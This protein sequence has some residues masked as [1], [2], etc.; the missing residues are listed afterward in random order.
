VRINAA[1][2]LGRMNAQN[3]YEKLLELL[4]P[5][6]TVPNVRLA[7]RKA[8]QALAG[9]TDHGYEVELWRREFDRS[10]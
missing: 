10:R 4:S 9:G 1:I 5:A 7:A 6:E 3:Q 2:A 8:L